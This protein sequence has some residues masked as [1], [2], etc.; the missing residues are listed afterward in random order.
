MNN[1]LQGLS[2]GTLFEIFTKKR[3]FLPVLSLLPSLSPRREV[4]VTRTQPP[5]PRWPI[6]TILCIAS[7]ELSSLFSEGSLR[8]TFVPLVEAGRGERGKKGHKI[9]FFWENNLSG[10][11]VRKLLLECV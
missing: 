9:V 2:N 11:V 6:F 1:T 4:G 7:M 10:G 5:D 3:L 8:L